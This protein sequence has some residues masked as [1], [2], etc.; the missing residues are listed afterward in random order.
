MNAEIYC[1]GN[2]QS[3]MLFVAKLLRRFVYPALTIET[4]SLE[5][6][7][8]WQDGQKIAS[9]LVKLMQA[10]IPP[11]LALRLLAK[12]DP[13]SGMLYLE[14]AYTGYRSYGFFGEKMRVFFPAVALHDRMCLVSANLDE[15]VKK[16]TK[17]DGSFRPIADAGVLAVDF[18][19]DRHLSQAVAEC[20]RQ[21]RDDIMAELVA[22]AGY[23]ENYDLNLAAKHIAV[24]RGY[25][26]HSLQAGAVERALCNKV[27]CSLPTPTVTLKTWT[28]IHLI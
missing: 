5:Q 3:E 9:R 11:R 20:G 25:L 14:F 16:W 15:S 17:T 6:N 13:A 26:I 27:E 4:F 21:I 12:E 2:Q 19:D 18:D 8:K 10:A 28:K 7:T 24:D 22:Y 1:F 23:E